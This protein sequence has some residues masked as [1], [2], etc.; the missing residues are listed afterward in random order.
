MHFGNSPRSRRCVVLNSNR[1]CPQEAITGVIS[2]RTPS[3]LQTRGASRVGSARYRR[4]QAEPRNLPT[5]SMEPLSRM[6]SV[7]A[8]REPFH[9]AA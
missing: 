9:H 5:S 6:E 7:P 4:S 8:D 3:I 1:V 2:V